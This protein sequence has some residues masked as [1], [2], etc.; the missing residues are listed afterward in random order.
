MQSTLKVG[1]WFSHKKLIVP[2]VH[3]QSCT[4]R[5]PYPTSRRRFCQGRWHRNSEHLWCFICWWELQTE[6]R[7][8]W[9]TLN[10]Q[11]WTEYKWLPVFHHMCQVWLPGREARSVWKDHRWLAGHEEDR[12]RAHRS[13]QQTQTTC[14]SNSVW[15]NVAPCSQAALGIIVGLF[16]CSSKHSVCTIHYL[17]SQMY[18]WAIPSFM[19]VFVSGLRGFPN[20][21]WR[22]T[23]AMV[24]A[25]EAFNS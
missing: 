12:E 9:A 18:P 2:W 14:S 11:Q 13:Q 25:V 17:L 5:S 4:I 6:A 21:N 1:G 10:G 22:L 3:K 24:Q 19:Y 15:R 20:I 23:C 7:F 16:C 8:P